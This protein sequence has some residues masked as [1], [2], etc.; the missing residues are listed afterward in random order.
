LRPFGPAQVLE[1]LAVHADHAAQR[2]A[3]GLPPPDALRLPCATCGGEFDAD[4]AAAEAESDDGPVPWPAGVAAGVRGWL[5]SR[6]FGRAAW[7]PALPAGAFRA[8]YGRTLPAR[9]AVDLRAAG[10]V[11]ETPPAALLEG[12]GVGGGAG[13]VV[14]YLGRVLAGRRGEADVSGLGL[15]QFPL[16]VLDLGRL[17]V[18]KAGDNCIR[19]LPAD[20]DRLTALE[21]LDLAHNVIQA[22]SESPLLCVPPLPTGAAAFVAATARGPFH[23]QHHPPC[24][25]LQAAPC[26]V[27]TTF[28]R[29]H[30]AFKRSWPV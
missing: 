16:E 11:I 7:A 18:L 6:V 29:P 3:Q 25:C 4:A 21:L 19:E 26:P 14:D 23:R 5:P 17:R 20:M 30:P 22:R 15:P 2:A 28:E 24:P 27:Q 9:A 12:V 8:C 1:R 10:D 13:R